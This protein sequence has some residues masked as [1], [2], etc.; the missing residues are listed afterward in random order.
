[1]NLSGLTAGVTYEL[2][3]YNRA[4]GSND[5][6]TVNIATT[7]GG[8]TT[9]DQDASAAGQA[10]LLRYTFVATGAAEAI[11]MTPTTGASFHLYG[12]TTEQVFNTSFV[13]GANWST[14][15]WNNSQTG[16]SVIPNYAGSNANFSAQGSPTTINL[17]ANETVGHIQ[18]DGANPW[19]ISS[20]NS[21]AFV[22][23]GDPGGVSVLSTLSGTHNITV[24][25]SVQNDVLKT[26]AG[27]L[28]VTNT[29]ASNGHQL[30]IG[31][32][33]L[34]F[35][36][37]VTA[38]GFDGN[39]VNQ[40]NLIV[41]NP[42]SLTYPAIVTGSGN[43]SKSG[44]GTL[45][46]A[47]G[48]SS[49][50][51]TTNISGGSVR[52]GGANSHYA[53]DGALGPIADGAAVT[54]SSVTGLAGAVSGNGASIVAGQFGQAINLGGTAHVSIADNASIDL[55]TYTISTWFNLSNANAFNGLIDTRNGGGNT[56]DLKVSA[57]SGGTA[58]VIHGDVGAGGGTWI[59]T[60]VDITGLTIHANE[61]HMVTYVVSNTGAQTYLDGVA[62]N[63]YAWNAS[64]LL[65][66]NGSLFFGNSDGSNLNG[67]IDDAYVVGT[68]L[69]A[70]QV[71]ALYTA[72]SN[73]NLPAAT[74][75]TIG[76][77]GSLDLNGNNQATVSLSGVSSAVVT[78]GSAGTSLLTLSPAGTTS[79]AGVIQDGSGSTRVTI[80]GAG[81]QE[82]AG[83][84]TYTGSTTVASGTLRIASTGSLAATTVTVG[85]SGANGAPTLS[86]SGTLAGTLVING[87]GAGV[88][89]HLAPGINTS[90]NFGAIGA[91]TTGSLILNT[92]SVLD[93][94]FASPGTSDLVAV[95][96]VLSLPTSGSVTLNL[97][98]AG[99]LGLGTYKLFTFGSLAST[100]SPTSINVGTTPLTGRSYNFTK[101]GNEIDLTIAKQAWSAGATTMA[102][103]LP[104]NWVSGLIPGSTGST[105]NTDSA[106]F[107]VATTNPANQTVLPDSG[108]N[109][110][111]VVFDAAAGAYTIGQTNG[112]ILHLTT[113]GSILS[114]ATVANIETVNAPLVIEGTS[115]SYAITNN[116]AASNV[117][118]IGG[119]ITGNGAGVSTLTLNGS[120]G[121]TVSGVISDGGSG[122]TVAVV[123]DGGGTWTLTGAH[124]FSAGTT[125]VNGTLRL[126]DGV[127]NGAVGD[128]VNGGALTFNNAVLQSYAG[129]IS[130]LGAINVNGAA[131]LIL[132]R[133]NG[134]S[135]TTTINGPSLRLG[136]GASSA[137]DGNL[138]G[139]I[140]NNM[141]LTFAN[142]GNLSY[143][144]AISGNGS[145]TKSGA[146]ALTIGGVNSYLGPTAVSAGTLRL[147][148][149]T[150]G[151]GALTISNA[152]F[153]TGTSGGG[154]TIRPIGAS[155]TFLNNSGVAT[156]GS[157]YGITNAPSGFGALLQNSG[158]NG[159]FF[160]TINFPTAG[161][162]SISFLLEGRPGYPLDPISV[163]FGNNTIPGLSSV[164]P[165]NTNSFDSFSGTFPVL[166][167]G[168]YT[169][170]FTS[171]GSA[172]GIDQ[173]TFVDNVAIAPYGTL[174]SGTVLSIA[175][176]AIF[177]LNAGNQ[178]VSSLTG[179]SGG[180]LTNSNAQ[181][182]SIVAAIPSG[183]S[184]FG[185]SIQDGVGQVNV[186]NFG[187]GA[188]VLSASNSYTGAT[189]ISGGQIQ[190][191]NA[192]AVQNST[193]TVNVNGGLTFAAGV[194]AP[195]IGGLSGSG[196][197]VLQ[198]S[199]GSPAP[200]TPSVGSNNASTN[201]AGA[202][203]GPGGLVKTGMGTLTLSAAN[204]Y[205]GST[206]I[207]GG[208][209]KLQGQVAIVAST[210]VFTTDAGSGIG[211]SSPYGA[212]GYTHALAFNTAG[213]TV[214]GLAF[215]N[216][217]QSGANYST[218][219]WGN[220]FTN[221][222]FN[223]AGPATNTL[224]GN[225][226]YGTGNPQT[227]TITGLNAGQS[228]DARIYYRQF[229][230][231]DRSA[232]WTFDPGTGSPVTLN[233][234]NEDANATGNYLDFTYVAGPMGML[235][236]SAA[237]HTGDSWHLYGFTNQFVSSNTTSSNTL[238]TGTAL[239]IA[240][241]A[242]LDLSGVS[243][244]V[245]SL[246]D[247]TGGGGSIVNSAPSTSATL[248][249][250]PASGSTTFSGVISDSGVA[251]AISLVNSGA[252]A[253]VLSG[254]NTYS[255]AT[256][257]NAGTLRTTATGNLGVGPLQVNSSGGLTTVELGSSQ[258]VSNLSGT[259]SVGSTANVKVDTG[260]IFSVTQSG[261]SISQAGL[262]LSTGT[263][264]TMLNPAG[265]AGVAAQ[266]KKDG[267]GSLTISGKTQLNDNTSVVVNG[268]TLVF[269]SAAASTIGAGVTATVAAAG[270][271]ELAGPVS[272]LGKSTPAANRAK[273]ANDGAIVASGMGQIVG[274]IDSITPG[275]GSVTVNGDLTADHINQSSLLIGSG[276]VF[277]LAASDAMGNSL[278]F[279]AMGGGSSSFA[280]L[281]AQPFGAGVNSGS[282]SSGGSSSAA[283]SGA[284]LGGGIGGGVAAVPEPA[285]IVLLLLGALAVAPL[286]RG[287]RNEN[288]H[289]VAR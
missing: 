65:A 98:D 274:G 289:N 103:S 199:A 43:V 129:L 12:F 11:N 164:L 200:V 282:L 21:S 216:A 48:F 99:G 157:A 75:I 31:G 18:F 3:F 55:H 277:T 66:Q 156:N 133:L 257:A 72:T 119:T 127:T 56:F 57:G 154:F 155:W 270:T 120:N 279:V 24:P 95:T 84:N 256:I 186:V 83:A 7:S 140:V 97:S 259:V 188:L 285:T 174:P 197:I 196:N 39:I 109:V 275:S 184:T 58:S 175:S 223:G 201:Y 100:F 168:S 195:N 167:A 27:T 36:D 229:G 281:A 153:T 249:L 146:G 209:L 262:E 159:T 126:G 45:T 25:V 276:G 30:T 61:W 162:Y 240:S 87:P 41:A 180:I 272:A 194:N 144:G 28:V 13:S 219:N 142:V 203:S 215:T 117:L 250:N 245:A 106:T 255:G 254:V 4:F 85:G 90:G 244:T 286:V 1:M 112:Q 10:N 166:A 15:T 163:Q 70:S 183:S 280:S 114:T 67:S 202:L 60:G 38:G 115:A 124:T 113:G 182:G 218:T 110:Q 73:G 158:N 170:G 222:T 173:T 198:D 134:A 94:D 228:Y 125:I 178:V 237:L 284:S 171:V 6:R 116:A 283:S 181:G 64:P 111:N 187:P 68:A 141:A 208:I 271:L 88:A 52:L 46:L 247:G 37:G 179:P 89:G 137:N 47:N 238:P 92:S 136:D 217:S 242:T 211:V 248:T 261:P 139:N 63:S 253:Q 267:G 169:I 227:L 69:S 149:S 51:G 121:G 145:L 96:N 118:N 210:N 236:L 221:S 207:N 128:I 260:T 5:N 29:V 235:T 132:T 288:H 19:T 239:Q 22:L 165:L 131:P 172:V 123:K 213:L 80:N 232:D 26:G 220:T 82:L 152:G 54:N 252:G 193:V 241:G 62:K 42:T 143:S 74:P 50:T 20:N 79:F 192:N 148:P 33:T 91:L 206:T 185:G 269:S 93:Y 138:A 214:N 258:T 224:L 231:A 190:I 150:T 71:A 287:S 234:V 17:D 44:A 102:W 151:A 226:I 104:G 265:T 191:A 35:G 189:L 9:F 147:G 266:L 105:T 160:Q 2:T 251:A 23:Q 176:G 40:G 14:A 278:P 86:G 225:F 8:S 101:V 59:N 233:N 212:S 263:A 122:N 243:Q 76:S 49:Y 81:V 77:G 32:G 246:A 204:T 16:T 177:D 53:L 130:G 268:G 230:A 161:T 264:P 107:N 78:N 108:R 34:Q 135:G 273:V 205:S